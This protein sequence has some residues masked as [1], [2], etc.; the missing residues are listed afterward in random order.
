M[1]K[2]KIPWVAPRAWQPAGPV[3]HVHGSTQPP[4]PALPPQGT[5]KLL[6]WLRDRGQAARSSVVSVWS[7]QGLLSCA[8]TSW[9]YF[10]PNTGCFCPSSSYSRWG[11][12]LQATEEYGSNSV[13][14][15][16]VPT[17]MCVPKVAPNSF[18]GPSM[19]C[20]VAFTSAQPRWVTG[21]PAALSPLLCFSTPLPARPLVSS[22]ACHLSLLLR[23]RV[24]AR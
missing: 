24:P 19:N 12:P 22:C 7:D 15:W 1:T 16:L 8:K 4:W 6:R 5:D 21:C 2:I 23:A 17:C 14:L 18:A 9:L 20:L 3:W 13:H 10:F 11:L